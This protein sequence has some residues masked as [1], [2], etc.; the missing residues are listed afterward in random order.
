MKDLSLLESQMYLDVVNKKLEIDLYLKDK[1]RRLVSFD[2]NLEKSVKLSALQMNNE[3]IN[4]TFKC[5]FNKIICEKVH[6]L[7]NRIK[8][9][10]NQKNGDSESLIA[11]GKMRLSFLYN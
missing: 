10:L 8:L 6:D 3:E 7:K 2:T 11:S 1:K 4:K 5:Q 9:S